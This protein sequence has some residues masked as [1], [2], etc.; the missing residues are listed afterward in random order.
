MLS[1]WIARLPSNSQQSQP[2]RALRRWSHAWH[3]R[4]TTAR[5]R[6]PETGFEPA[7]L[8]TAG[9]KPTVSTRFHHSGPYDATLAGIRA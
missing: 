3:G 7:S 5:P 4:P 2:E 6:V 8:T 9:F 1:Y